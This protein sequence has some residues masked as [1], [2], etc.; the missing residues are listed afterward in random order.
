MW[1]A[2]FNGIFS[3]YEFGVFYQVPLDYR[4]E[5]SS[6]YCRVSVLS[7]FK[8]FLAKGIITTFAGRDWVFPLQSEPAV[9][10]PLSA[11]QELA[12]DSAGN[13]YVADSADNVVVKVDPSG[14]STVFAG[15]GIAGYT[16][17]G[18]TA[19]SSSMS[20]P[21]SVAVDAA[22][23]V[24][25]ADENNNAIRKVGTNGIITTFA[26]TGNFAFTADGAPASGSAIESPRQLAIGPGNTL[27]FVENALWARMI[28]GN[29]VLHTI[30][31]NG[32]AGNTPDGGSASR[33]SLNEI[34]GVAVDSAGNVYL[35]E[36]SGNR[37]RK[38]NTS[39]I[40]STVTGN[41]AATFTGDGG[42]ATSATVWGP[43][44]LALDSNGDLFIADTNNKRVH[45]WSI[46]RAL[47]PPSRVRVVSD[48]AEMPD[49]QRVRCSGFRTVSPSMVPET[50]ISRTAP[51]C[52]Y[53]DLRSGKTLR[54]LR[55]M[56]SIAI[57]SQRRAG[58]PVVLIG[59]VRTRVC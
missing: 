48:S 59:C 19:T 32:V 5:F 2:S 58:Q 22:G 6:R 38:V 52:G 30:A 31:G 4:Y 55:A 14:N 49:R 33:A 17:D 3:K 27:Y 15:N 1:A 21:E 36:F 44:G 42:P 46:R 37:V 18:G 25:I 8:P 7:D 16:G 54:P 9:S 12:V 50:S 23:N 10:A 51:I 40:L 29:G 20:Y 39:G 34:N 43:W 57:R 35:S 28:D 47:L 45:V 24:Y 53:G 56:D 11:I 13:L 41:G 26:G